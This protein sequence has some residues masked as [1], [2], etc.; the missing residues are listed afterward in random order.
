MSLQQV[1]GAVITIGSILYFLAMPV[2][3]RVYREADIGRRA[4]I[5]AANGTRWIAS[6]ALFA[7]G[8]L[9]PAAGF[10]L[11]SLSWGASQPGP[12]IF[13]GA[14]AFLI[15]AINGAYLIYRQTLDPAAFWEDTLPIPHII[16][17]LYIILTLLGLVIYGITFIQGGFPD[18]IG[19]LMTGAGVVMLIAFLVLRGEGGFFLSVLIYLVTFIAGIVIAVP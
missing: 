6:Q 10:L 4:A 7:L 19:Y 14:A 11:L 1:S 3:P 2:A 12:L 8:M 5:I 16:G 15:G 13:L 18:W 17:Y 9:V